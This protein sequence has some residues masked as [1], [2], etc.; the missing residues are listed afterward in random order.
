M[1]HDMEHAIVVTVNKNPSICIADCNP[2]SS[3]YE[4]NQANA[5][6]IAAAPEL[7]A[8]LDSLINRS[9][10]M[11]DAWDQDD[12]YINFDNAVDQ[13]RAAIAKATGEAS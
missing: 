2:T 4:V 5:R 11:R 7:L 6:L 13:A 10:D 8:A 12:A 1:L 9:L 3:S